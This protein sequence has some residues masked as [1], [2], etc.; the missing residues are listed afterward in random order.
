MKFESKIKECNIIKD[1]V[2]DIINDYDADVA[3]TALLALVYLIM[4][5]LKE[6]TRT[7]FIESAQESLILVK[8]NDWNEIRKE[9]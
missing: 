1:K 3:I 4:D 2:I 9:K 6:P 7:H 8:N 5:N